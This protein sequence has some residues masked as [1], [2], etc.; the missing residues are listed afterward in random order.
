MKPD[1]KTIQQFAD[2]LKKYE[3]GNLE[4]AEL[5]RR[6]NN[7]KPSRTYTSNWRA[8]ANST[9]LVKTLN[10][11][12]DEVEQKRLAEIVEQILRDRGR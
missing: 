4:W 8:L 9:R 5:W 6:T 10:I 11:P 3:W 7:I 1:N 2:Q 12:T